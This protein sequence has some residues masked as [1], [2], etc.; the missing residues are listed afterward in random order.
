LEKYLGPKEMECG[1]EENDI[2]MDFVLKQ[3]VTVG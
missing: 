1:S 3:F 2:T